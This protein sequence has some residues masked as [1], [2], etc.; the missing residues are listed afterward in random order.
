MIPRP[1][2]P[3]HPVCQLFTAHKAVEPYPVGVVAVPEQILG[4]SFFPGGSGL[5]CEDGDGAPR[6]PIGGVMV[7][8]HDYHN[9]AGYEWSRRNV[10]ENLR[11]PTW[12]HLL[13][14]L[15]RVPIDPASCFFTNIYMGL[16]EGDGTT[17]RFPGAGDADFK[18]R[19]RSFL[20]EQIRAQRP[21][22]ILALGSWVPEFLAPL[23]PDLAA[24]SRIQSLKTLD[25]AGL[26]LI[27]GVKFNGVAD[28]ECSVVS[29]VHPCHRPLNV[30]RR[31]W[32]TWTGD[33]AEV[34]MLKHAHQSTARCG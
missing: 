9:V 28:H 16:R 11:S 27:A 21:R 12:R 3:G 4:T 31:K 17:G 25:A 1:F 32:R 30:H 34:E 29:L 33:D 19:C 10:A 14:L 26:P 15:A 18:Q 7:L 23:S 20:I 8:G 22:L 5:W 24:W 2:G 13:N 6:L